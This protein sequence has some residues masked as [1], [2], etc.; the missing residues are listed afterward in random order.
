MSKIFL[1]PGI[2]ESENITMYCNYARMNPYE[3]RVHQPVS[4]VSVVEEKEEARKNLEEKSVKEIKEILAASDVD[5]A[6][7]KNLKKDELIDLAISISFGK[8]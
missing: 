4:S 2:N 5:E 8:E 7:Y 6:Q 1:V 3:E